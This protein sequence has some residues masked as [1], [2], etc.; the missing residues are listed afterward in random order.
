MEFD[1]EKFEREIKDVRLGEQVE[2][3]V[4]IK[5]GNLLNDFTKNQF[6]DWRQ[7]MGSIVRDMIQSNKDD[8]EA[9][10]EVMIL[11]LLQMIH[12]LARHDVLLEYVE[13]YNAKMLQQ[14]RKIDERNTALI[15]LLAAKGIISAEDF[16]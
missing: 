5:F 4:N 10:A 15:Q 2:A 12:Q 16:A 9:A 6:L 13:G 8:P 14:F 11:I 1:W 7:K 3:D